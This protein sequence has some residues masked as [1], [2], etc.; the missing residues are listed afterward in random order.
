MTCS[1]GHQDETAALYR[2]YHTY[3]LPS[4]N[5]FVSEDAG[6]VWQVR[7]QQGRF[8]DEQGTGYRRALLVIGDTEVGVYVVLGCAQAGARGED[9]VVSKLDLANSDWLEELG[10]DFGR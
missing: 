1:T 7:V 2:R 6:S 8:A 4:N 9:D 3:L 10:D 5:L